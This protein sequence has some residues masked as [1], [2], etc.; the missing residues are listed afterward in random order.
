MHLSFVIQILLKVFTSKLAEMQWPSLSVILSEIF[1]AYIV[2]SIYT[3]SLLF[4]SP[5]CEDGKPC[6]ESYLSERPQLDLY[7]YSSIKRNPIN[8]DADLVYSA[9]NFDYN[10]MQIMWVSPWASFRACSSSR[11]FH[12]CLILFENDKDEMMLTN[13]ANIKWNRLIL[14]QTVHVN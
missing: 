1:L 7:M 8:R 2:Y 14:N 9:Q 6:L 11:S 5:A 13:I 3:L 4:V 10:Q 12:P